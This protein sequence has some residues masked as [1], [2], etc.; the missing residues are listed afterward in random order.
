MHQLF[1][2]ISKA[3][4]FVNVAVDPR[5]IFEILQQR[6]CLLLDL[7][8][9]VNT[10]V[11]P[12]LIQPRPA[13]FRA[14]DLPCEL[15]YNLVGVL[16]KTLE[17]VLKNHAIIFSSCELITMHLSQVYDYDIESILFFLNFA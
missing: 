14:G 1:D 5:V 15:C 17:C 10:Q 13:G 2:P 3:E 6:L 16:D 11:Q 12:F 9:L 8:R 7:F 4:C